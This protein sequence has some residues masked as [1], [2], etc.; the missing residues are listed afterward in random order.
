MD[1]LKD[2]IIRYPDAYLH[3]RAS[4]QGVS[5]RGITHALK[6]L[7]VSYKKNTL[8][9]QSGRREAYFIQK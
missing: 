4:R 3:E 1:L 8:S 9:P 6:R 2:D 5:I 7:G